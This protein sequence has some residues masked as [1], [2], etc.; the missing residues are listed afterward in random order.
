M[1]FIG[2]IIYFISTFF[3][4]HKSF[5]TARIRGIPK[6]SDKRMLKIIPDQ[7]S[8]S[9]VKESNKKGISP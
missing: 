5:Q 9:P 7:S 2:M 4:F 6:M 1:Q 3:R 8:F